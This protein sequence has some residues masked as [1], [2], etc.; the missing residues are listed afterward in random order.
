MSKKSDEQLIAKLL[1]IVVDAIMHGMPVT[2]KVADARN[3]AVQ[4]LPKE[5]FTDE[6]PTRKARR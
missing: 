6:H 1:E 3:M 2:K 4:R 5:S